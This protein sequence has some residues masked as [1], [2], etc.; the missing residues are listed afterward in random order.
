[1]IIFISTRNEMILAKMN[2]LQDDTNFIKSTGLEI[3]GKM[4][5]EPVSSLAISRKPLPPVSRSYVQRPEIEAFVTDGLQRERHLERQPRC[6][7]HGMGGSGKTQAA[8][9]WIKKHMHL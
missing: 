7:L 2:N 3:L 8:C 1:M 6:V 5:G 4:N 9:A